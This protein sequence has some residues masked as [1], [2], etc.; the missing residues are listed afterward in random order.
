[1]AYCSE[2]DV[3]NAASIIA[4]QISDSDVDIAVT[5]AQ[6]VIDA[7]LAARYVV[8]FPSYGDPVPTPPVIRSICADLAAY[9]AIS[10]KYL[11]GGEKSPS[12]AAIK[13]EQDAMALLKS[14]ADPKDPSTIPGTPPPTQ[15]A[16]SSPGQNFL[17]NFDLV[18]GPR[19]YQHGIPFA[20]VRYD[21]GPFHR[22]WFP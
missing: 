2:S 22:T 7:K 14:L 13:L 18:N 12:P 3:G 17:Q 21:C 11:A 5:W 6:S 16:M 8:P 19:P 9:K 10:A 4:E 20:P 15:M 1:M